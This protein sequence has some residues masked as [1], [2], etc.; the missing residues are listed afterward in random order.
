V[1]R[2]GK[3]EALREEI[4]MPLTPR[5]RGGWERAI[6]ISRTA[7]G[8]K[9]FSKVREEGRLASLDRVHGKVSQ[10]PARLASS[11]SQRRHRCFVERTVSG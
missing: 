5:S 1:E 11:G 8:E 2:L 3:L 9:S 7:L 4:G 6:E 10:R